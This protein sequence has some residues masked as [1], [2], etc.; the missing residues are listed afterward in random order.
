MSSAYIQTVKHTNACR[1]HAQFA[2]LPTGML[3][4]LLLALL[5][6]I[7]QF[8]VAEPARQDKAI[9]GGRLFV[10]AEIHQHPFVIITPNADELFIDEGIIS[11]A[12]GTSVYLL[13][14]TRI[15][16]VDRQVISIVSTKHR[17]AIEETVRRE[18]IEFAKSVMLRRTKEYKITDVRFFYSKPVP[19][20]GGESVIAEKLP[21]T[22]VL[23]VRV[24]ISHPLPQ[25]ALKTKSYE[26][27]HLKANGTVIFFRQCD[28]VY[29]WGKRPENIM[30]ML[31]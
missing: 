24:H 17:E 3:P 27:D 2:W 1:S 18:R 5:L 9:N 22:A 14:G 15:K 11:A 23:P 31:A 20:N 26:K 7:P 30:V 19:H 8:N 28:P 29:S 6:G 4:F 25:S 21:A 12:S 16:A 10:E 13:P